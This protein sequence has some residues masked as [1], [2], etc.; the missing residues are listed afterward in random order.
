MSMLPNGVW[1]SKEQNP[2][3]KV[4]GYF[5]DWSIYQR[6]YYLKNISDK[7]IS[8]KIDSVIFSFANIYEADKKYFDEHI[9]SGNKQLGE[10][11]DFPDRYYTN[12]DEAT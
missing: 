8:H 10:G 9:F 11:H 1:N 4:S 12:L 3:A 2:Q 6:Q 7:V 5:P